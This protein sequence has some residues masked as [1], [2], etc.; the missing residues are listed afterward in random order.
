MCCFIHRY[1]SDDFPDPVNAYS[2]DKVIVAL[3]MPTSSVKTSDNCD[4]NL[5]DFFYIGLS[6]IICFNHA[7]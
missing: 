1:L 4:L 7:S 2:M 6:N 5:T 3:F